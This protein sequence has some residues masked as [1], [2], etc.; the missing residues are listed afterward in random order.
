M[1]YRSTWHQ[2][3]RDFEKRSGSISAARLI[4][5]VIAVIVLL[6]SPLMFSLAILTAIRLRNIGPL[7]ILVPILIAA[8]GW[9]CRLRVPK[10]PKGAVEVSD[11]PVFQ[12]LL[13][14]I[15]KSLNAPKIQLI[16]FSPEINASVSLVS[17]SRIPHLTL[18]RPV[19]YLLSEDQL[20]ALLAHEI[21]HLVNDDPTQGFL[22]GNALST[23]A[24][25]GLTDPATKG[26]RRTPYGWM[27]LIPWI[28]L[29]SLLSVVEWILVNTSARDSQRAEYRADLL[30]AE[31]AGPESVV[32]LFEN[33]AQDDL[34][35][36]ACRK[37]GIQ[38]F[39]FDRFCENLLIHVQSE[40]R[41]G[42]VGSLAPKT[43]GRRTPH[44]RRP[45]FESNCS[46]PN[47]GRCRGSSTLTIMNLCSVSYNH[48][49]FRVGVLRRR[50]RAFAAPIIWP[51]W[52]HIRRSVGW[53]VGCRDRRPRT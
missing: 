19:P 3:L 28:I 53:R 20:L 22:Y 31:L 16:S 32:G 4:G 37:A 39:Q 9:I 40:K 43:F 8:I 30:A 44:I 5:S 45:N 21:A 17:F 13:D 2:S 52:L 11:L 50:G 42:L 1:R 47:L 7:G 18:G 51:I 26:L 12:A 33:M 29:R 49:F 35:A 34:V 15:A 48:S 10:R 24:R 36:Y 14:S 41:F 38:T 23:L 6:F 27:L 46:R 25:S